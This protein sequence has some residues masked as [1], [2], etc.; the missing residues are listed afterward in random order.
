MRHPMTMA[1]LGAYLASTVSRNVLLFCDAANRVEELQNRLLELTEQMNNIQAK[2]DAEK[3][4]LT[5]DESK[6]IDEMFA[7]FREVEADIDR[8]NRLADVN[9][10]AAQPQGRKTEP[11]GGAPTGVD[12]QNGQRQVRPRIPANAADLNDVGKWGFKS[13]GEFARSVKAAVRSSPGSIDPR[14]IAN[15]APNEYGREGVGEDGGFAVPP[16]FRREIMVKV[17]GEASLLA[18]TD[19]QTSS[20]NTLVIPKDETTPWQS[21]GGIQA[22]WEGEGG[23]YTPGKPKLEPATIRLNKLT[24][25]VPVTEELLEDAAALSNYLRTKTPQKMDFKVTDAILNGTGAG[26]PLGI[27]NSDALVTVTQESAQAADTIVFNNIVNMW[28][29]LYSGCRANAVWLI[30]QDIEPQLLGLQFPGSG[31]AV[32]VYLPPGG[33][34]QSPFGMLMGRPVIPTEACPT[35]GDKGD[36]ILADLS[37]YLTAM[38]TQGIRQDVSMHLW[39][40]YDIV[41]FKFTM[42]LAGQPWWS[43]PIQPKNGSNTRGCFVALEERA[44]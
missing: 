31:T 25:L 2:A 43:A 29:R 7:E 1:A 9:A 3:R 33:L 30:N 34:S 24:A 15:A 14:L 41:A 44:G 42:R 11:E 32:P 20:S 27:L 28:A 17:A 40:D 4:P 6:L 13:F 35:L 10:R 5:E 36:I 22:Y 16:D 26:M 38:R 8:R 19:R 39:F 23:Q 18:R 21:T 12:P 37:T